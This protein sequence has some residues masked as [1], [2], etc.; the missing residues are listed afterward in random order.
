MSPRAEGTGLIVVGGEALID[1]K[2]SGDGAYVP[3]PGG[4]PFNTAVALG[5]LGVPVAF[6]GRLSSDGFGE[7]CRARLV[8]AG[9]D[10]TMAPTAEEPTTLAV[11]DFA[12]NGDARYHFYLDG[13]SAPALLPDDVAT[14]TARDDITALH[15]GTLGLVL[16]PMA[17]TLVSLLEQHHAGRVVMVDPNIRPA[18]V[19]DPISYLERFHDWLPWIDVV[20][21]SDADIGHLSPGAEPIAVAQDWVARG[22]IAVCLTQGGKGTLLVTADAEPAFVPATPVEVVDTIGA[23][24]TFSAGFLCWL[25][26]RGLLTSDALR[27]LPV[28]ELSDAVAFASRCAALTCARPG[29]DPPWRHELP[30]DAATA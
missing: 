29:A 9:V 10:L 30:Q 28:R 5:R 19:R 26:D 17:S 16:E 4:G 25:H 6:L 3:H 27:S 21:V 2:P 23:G 15:L 1:L 14:S 8:Q 20:K 7:R 13:T 12:D 18:L 24:D 11:V 22:A